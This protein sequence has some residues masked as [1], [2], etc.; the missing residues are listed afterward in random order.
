MLLKLLLSCVQGQIVT[1]NICRNGRFPTG[2]VPVAYMT[3][4]QKSKHQKRRLHGACPRGYHD[5]F[6][7]KRKRTTFGTEFGVP[8]NFQA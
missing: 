1:I 2:L 7:I 3:D 8:K 5:L 4:Y 6:G